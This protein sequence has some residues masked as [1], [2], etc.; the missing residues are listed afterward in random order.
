MQQ[1][2][3]LRPSNKRTNLANLNCILMAIDFNKH[4]STITQPLTALTWIL[5]G[6][7]DFQAS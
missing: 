2:V 7:I 4:A 1:N 5:C 6:D 3:E